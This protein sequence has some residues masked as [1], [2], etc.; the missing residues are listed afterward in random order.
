MRSELMRAKP[1]ST[2]T[3]LKSRASN[4]IVFVESEVKHGIFK[5]KFDF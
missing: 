2:M 4:L 5:K 3:A 1:E